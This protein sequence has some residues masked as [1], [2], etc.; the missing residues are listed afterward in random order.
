MRAVR[1]LLPQAAAELLLAVA[2][3]LSAAQWSYAGD[4]DI[5]YSLLNL[6]GDRWQYTYD[7]TNNEI[8]I[9]LTC[10]LSHYF[11]PSFVGETSGF[12]FIQRHY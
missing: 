2:V 8:R 3:L 7:V 1:Q 12:I 4:V 11:P 10:E 5:S 9:P 6:G